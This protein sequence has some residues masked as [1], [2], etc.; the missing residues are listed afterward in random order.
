MLWPVPG[1][2][3]MLTVIEIGPV[4]VLISV[5]ATRAQPFVEALFDPARRTGG[6]HEELLSTVP[7]DT[8]IFPQLG[9][10]CTG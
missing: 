5:S 9:L 6:D 8:V 4:F 10:E 7:A 3:P 2:T 1:A